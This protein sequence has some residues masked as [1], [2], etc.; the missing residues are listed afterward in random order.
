MPVY[1]FQCI[2]CKNEFE[3]MCS[4]KD[5]ENIRC[6]KCKGK[7]K[8]KFSVP[9]IAFKGSGFYKTD[10][11]SGSVS[12]NEVKSATETVTSESRPLAKSKTE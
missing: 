3:E 7:S 10:S 2:K 8:K 5:I 4:Y 6:P 11:G 9:S 1:E 12:T